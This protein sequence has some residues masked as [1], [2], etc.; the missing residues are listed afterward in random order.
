MSLTRIKQ[1]PLR[2][3]DGGKRNVRTQFGALCWRV[4]NDKVQ[5]LLIT[6]RRRKRWILP[7]GWP[8]DEATPVEA[9]QT[10]AWEEAGVTGKAKSVCLGIYS[11]IKEMDE[12]EQLPCVVA[13]FPV[14]VKKIRSDW[15]EK[16]MRRRKWMS[17]KEASKAVA[18]KELAD[19]IAGFDP[20][21]L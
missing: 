19:I 14:K 16:S 11:Y 3:A 1:R 9:A 4:V 2:L 18:E 8:M 17:L 5:V 6:S 7:K 15:P 12:G 10:E 20:D 21:D 13:V